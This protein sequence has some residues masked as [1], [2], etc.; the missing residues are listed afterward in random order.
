VVD[1]CFG[2]GKMPVREEVQS[3]NQRYTK[4]SS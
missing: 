2:M 3:A 4:E 1:T